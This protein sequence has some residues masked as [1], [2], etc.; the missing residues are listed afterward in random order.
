LARGLPEPKRIL[1]EAM[2]R[3]DDRAERLGQA[4]L[5]LVA[6]RGTRLAEAAGGLRK[7][8]LERMVQHG[9]QDVDHAVER[10]KPAV[11]RRLTELKQRLKHAGAL[12]DSYSYERVLERGFALVS[13]ASGHPVTS[14]AALAPGMAVGLRFGDG[15][16]KAEITATGAAA[17][18][19][20]K[21]KAAKSM[22][23]KAKP[24]RNGKQGSLL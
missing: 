5:G 11:T 13:D 15:A 18:G 10:L 21:P 16:A 6:R 22:P 8:T 17:P 19:P 4:L 12:L 24:S 7:S 9:R 3:L 20:A 2:Q 14:A 23:A 1:D